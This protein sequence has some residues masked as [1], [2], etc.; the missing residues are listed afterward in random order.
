[1]RFM[2]VH[3]FKRESH[4]EMMIT[5][6]AEEQGLYENFLKS[7]HTTSDTT[8]QIFALAS[9]DLTTEFGPTFLSRLPVSH[10]G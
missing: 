8:K 1:M 6:A 2:T 3:T 4:S 10:F 7:D 5:S 9:L